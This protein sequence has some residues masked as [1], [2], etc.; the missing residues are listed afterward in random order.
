MKSRYFLFFVWVVS[1]SIQLEAM[2]KPLTSQKSFKLLRLPDYECEFGTIASSDFKPNE[3]KLQE[4][5]MKDQPK[6]VKGLMEAIKIVLEPIKTDSYAARILENLPYILTMDA[7]KILLERCSVY[8]TFLEIKQSKDNRNV[9]GCKKRYLAVA[10]PLA[11]A[12]AFFSPF[13]KETILAEGAFGLAS[14]L[15]NHI[16]LATKEY[17]IEE[18]IATL[19]GHLDTSITL[20]SNNSVQ[21]RDRACNSLEQSANRA[22]MSYCIQHH[23]NPI[24]TELTSLKRVVVDGHAESQRQHQIT[25]SKID[26]LAELVKSGNSSLKE[27]TKE[28]I[29]NAIKKIQAGRQEQ[30]TTLLAAVTL[31]RLPQLTDIGGQKMRFDLSRLNLSSSLTPL[32]PQRQ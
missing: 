31:G 6:A 22:Y 28:E 25:Q 20:F 32:S 29:D 1:F 21:V 5:I 2:N 10:L 18:K 9:L 16:Y 14:L 26:D 4:K 30:T 24:H 12:G 11:C 13:P 3:V 17:G 23:I 8:K 27:H 7:A 15:A 19:R